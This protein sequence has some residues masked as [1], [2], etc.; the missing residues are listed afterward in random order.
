MVKTFLLFKPLKSRMF[1]TKCYVAGCMQDYYG[2][3]TMAY[4]ILSCDGE[5]GDYHPGWMTEEQ[6]YEY[7]IF[8]DP[9][10]QV[11]YGK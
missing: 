7:Y 3:D 6:V 10:H 9:K 5:T 11:L 1:G 4:Q 8:I 2:K